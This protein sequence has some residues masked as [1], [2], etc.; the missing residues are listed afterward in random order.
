MTSMAAGLA[1]AFAGAVA[2]NASYLLQHAGTRD[3]PAL[4]LRR[5]RR[6][7]AVLLGSGRWLAGLATGM[8]GWAR[9]GAGLAA[10]PLS[11]VQAFA[12]GGLALTV[13]AA[14]RF[15]GERLSRRE[16]LAMVAMVVA[17]ALLGIGATA[18]SLDAV[19]GTR[20]AVFAAVAAVAAACATVPAR[21]AARGRTLAVAAGVLYGTADAAAKAVVIEAGHGLP[22]ALLGPWAAIGALVTFGAFVAFQRGLQ[23][24]P[25]V[26]VIALMTAGTTVVGVLGGLLV[27][28]DPL[29][30]R[31]VAALHVGA[32]AVAAVAG[33]V[34]AAAQARLAPADTAGPEAGLA[35][36]TPHGGP[37]ERTVRTVAM[38][39]RPGPL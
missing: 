22:G 29:G 13:P 12:A 3:G 24:G 32:F 34:L 35:R 15:L 23:L 37:P 1:A 17:L 6:S 30:T 7:A 27:F 28:G 2:L 19:P 8:A 5:P 14:A 18:S 39:A 21:G 11:L 10:A 36:A 26:P 33:L 20:M 31:A 16:R 25:A 38:D 4:D 9:F